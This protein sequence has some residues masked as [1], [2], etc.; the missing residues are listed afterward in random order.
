MRAD[1]VLLV[2]ADSHIEDLVS[3]ALDSQTHLT[4][5]TGTE[6]LDTLH[7]RDFDTLIVTDGLAG[8]DPLDFIRAIRREFPTLP[9]GFIS[10]SD[11]GVLASE[12]L[13]GGVD[14]YIPLS[15][16]STNPD[17]LQSGLDRAVQVRSLSGPSDELAALHTATRAMIAADSVDALAACVIEACVDVLGLN[18]AS[19]YSVDDEE[20]TLVPVAWTEQLEETIDEPPSLN[21]DSLAWP[22]FANTSTKYYADVST[23]DRTPTIGTAFRTNFFVPLGEHGLFSI[24]SPEQDAFDAQQREIVSILGANATAALDAIAQTAELRETTQSLESQ[25]KQL[26]QFVS[27]VSHDLRSPLSVAEGRLKL[28]REECDSEHLDTVVSAH[29][30]MSTLIEDLLVLARSREQVDE[31]E[32]VDLASLVDRCWRHVATDEA[33]LVTNID[34]RIQADQSRLQQ[35]LENLM[36]NAVEHGGSDVTVTIGAVDTGFYFEDDGPGIPK[37]KRDEVF[38]AGYS[39]TENGTGFGLSIVKQVAEAHG[40]DIDVTDSSEGGARF[41]ITGVESAA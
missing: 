14:D 36:R 23:V 38:E 10:E 1:H 24:F 41:E 12:A 28:A 16:L 29:A 17:R 35:L 21:P 34:K 2:A 18:Y 9:I 31:F 30:R 25:N 11:S 8:T 19:V 39:T 27:I 7:E 13:A 40:W 3:T 22:A 37:A 6:A 33:T 15:I 26:D 5:A 32:T 4:V 20:T